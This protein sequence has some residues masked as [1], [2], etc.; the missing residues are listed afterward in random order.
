MCKVA[1]QQWGRIFES[2]LWRRPPGSQGPPPVAVNKIIVE[3]S[4]A[5]RSFCTR[6]AFSMLVGSRLPCNTQEATGLEHVSVGDVAKE[7]EC[8]EGRDVELDTYI[9]DEEKVLRICNLAYISSYVLSCACGNARHA[10]D[11]PCS[12]RRFGS[13][14]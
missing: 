5:L 8:F 12:L 7:K 13:C 4:S 11:S 9:L 1:N 6:P 14:D 2:A 3:G 10:P